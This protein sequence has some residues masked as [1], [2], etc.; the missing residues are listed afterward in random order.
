M[1]IRWIV[2]FFCIVAGFFLKCKDILL[3]QGHQLPG[4]AG[5]VP[6]QVP[7]HLRQAGIPG[8]LC[9]PVILPGG[10]EV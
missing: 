9:R 5:L 4:V 6:G 10:A 2:E 1:F 3:Q 8:A 7:E